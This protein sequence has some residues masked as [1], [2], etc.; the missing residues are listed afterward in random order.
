MTKREMKK[1][2]MAGWATLWLTATAI[3]SVVVFA[4]A[5]RLLDSL[6]L[7]SIAATL[8]IALVGSWAGTLLTS[9]WSR[10]ARALTDGIASLKDRDFSLSVTPATHDEMGDLVA[11]YNDLGERLRIERQ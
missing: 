7:A 6:W 9:R 5:W 1:W 8:A 3:V 4:M 11:I 10:M 2:S